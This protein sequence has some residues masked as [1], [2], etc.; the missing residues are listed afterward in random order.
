MYFLIINHNFECSN[1]EF[2]TN[3]TILFLSTYQPVLPAGL[4]YGMS[5]LSISIQPAAP[6]SPNG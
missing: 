6:A 3:V 2:E 5:G 4:P 1:D